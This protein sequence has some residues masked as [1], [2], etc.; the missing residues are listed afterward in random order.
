MDDIAPIEELAQIWIDFCD[1]PDYAAIVV[2]PFA[3]VA[4]HVWSVMFPVPQALPKCDTLGCPGHLG[5]YDSCLDEIL[6]GWA[7]DVPTA[8]TGDCSTIGWWLALVEVADEVLER[9]DDPDRIVDI[10]AGWYIVEEWD[11][12]YV[13]VQHFATEA[14]ARAQRF[15][16]AEAQC[17]DF[18]ESPEPT[19]GF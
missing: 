4:N 10:P 12:G 3:F 17:A 15:D 9:R 8:Q 16:L 6:H 11:N 2:R 7:I 18:E 13:S 14:E 5:K 19:D 1:D